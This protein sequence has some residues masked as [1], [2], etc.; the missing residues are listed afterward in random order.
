MKAL[1]KNKKCPDVSSMCHKRK[2]K[3]HWE[4]S[5]IYKLF[6]QMDEVES[7]AEEMG[8]LFHENSA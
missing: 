5:P 4:K 2:T 1:R 6:G 3:G 8:G 7:A